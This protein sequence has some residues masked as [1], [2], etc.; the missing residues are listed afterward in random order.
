MLSL[1]QTAGTAVEDPKAQLE[2]ARKAWKDKNR[3]DREMSRLRSYARMTPSM[4]D[5][6]ASYSSL[7][8]RALETLNRILGA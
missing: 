5:D 8:T 3:A 7:M 4:K 1:Y 6:F 2:E